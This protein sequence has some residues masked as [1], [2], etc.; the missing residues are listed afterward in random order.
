MKAEIT[1]H[2]L[3]R[4]RELLYF[5]FRAPSI[6]QLDKLFRRAYCRGAE[7][8]EAISNYVEKNDIDVDRLE[9]MF[10]YMPIDELAKEFGI[11][12][13]IQYKQQ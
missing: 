12:L 6:K 7:L 1:F 5:F 10:Y 13:I 2:R 8:E 11:E 9:D 4:N 3:Y